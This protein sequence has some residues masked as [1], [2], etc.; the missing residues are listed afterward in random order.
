MDF[1]E[2]VFGILGSVFFVSFFGFHYSEH[3]KDGLRH[4]RG[5]EIEVPEDEKRYLDEEMYGKGREIKRYKRTDEQIK[6]DAYSILFWK[7]VWVSLILIVFLSLF[8]DT[9]GIVDMFDE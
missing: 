2:F 1:L 7:G 4:D 9:F 5:D 3:K 8:L 6:W